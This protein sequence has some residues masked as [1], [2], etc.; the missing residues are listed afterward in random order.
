MPHHGKR[1]REL[2]QLVDR[3]QVYAPDAA[4]ELLK[5]T[6]RVNFDPAVEVPAVPSPAGDI[7]GAAPAPT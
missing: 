4:M 1:Y 6:S 3:E 7:L 2:A 5:D